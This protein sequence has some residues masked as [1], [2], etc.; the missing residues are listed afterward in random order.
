[1]AII[2]M[3]RELGSL[4]TVIGTQAAKRLNYD[5]VYQEITSTAARDYEVMEEKLIRVVEKPPRFLEKLSG[6]FRR[7]QTFV[8]AQVFKIAEK[9]NV[10]LIGRWSTLLLRGIDH[11]LRVRVTAPL[12]V[13]A[14]RVEKMM[15]VGGERALELVKQNDLERG[16][17]MRQLYDIDWTAPH[18]YDLVLN[19]EKISVEAGTTLIVELIQNQEFR[20]TKASEKKIHNL[21]VAS[22]IRA[23]LKA[24]R[25]TRD[26][27]V[28]IQVRDGHVILMGVVASEAEKRAAERVVGAMKG[29]ERVDSHLRVM[30]HAGR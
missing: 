27:D 15:Q 17:R 3:S 12:E 24:H 7:Y 13:R 9:N 10:V 5:Y 6:D 23:E 8:Q 25:S 30:A 18:L 4:G 21:A 28:D 19:T 26:V 29:T 1:M 14:R 20:T 22:A 16:E 2:A 11:A